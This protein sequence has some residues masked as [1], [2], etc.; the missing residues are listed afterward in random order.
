MT[1]KSIEKHQVK[2]SIGVAVVVILSLLTMAFNLATWKAEMQAEHQEFDD[3]ITHVGDKIIGMRTDINA[4]NEQAD[5]RD[6]QLATINTKLA[7]IEALLIEIKTDLKTHDN[8]G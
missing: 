4:L 2:I 8:G 5:A 7:N 3:R 6:I 1:E